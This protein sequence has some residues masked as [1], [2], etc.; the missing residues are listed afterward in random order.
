[1]VPSA[2]GAM[3]RARVSGRAAPIQVPR[4]A[5]VAS[6]GGRPPGRPLLPRV[7]LP[8]G[9]PLAGA[10][11]DGALP[12]A[13]SRAWGSNRC[14]FATG[15]AYCRGVGRGGGPSGPPRWRPVEVAEERRRR[16]RVSKPPSKGD[17]GFETRAAARCAPQPAESSA[18]LRGALLNPL[19]L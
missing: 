5:G 16:R 11:F 12:R 10:F 18:P 8:L 9:L 7:F 13:R 1:P 14:C 6:A 2:T 17:A 4:V 19:S 15:E 3:A